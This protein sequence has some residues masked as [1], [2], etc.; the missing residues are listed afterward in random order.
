MSITD[1]EVR[2]TKAR[3]GK[4]TK[5]SVGHGLQLWAHPSGRRSWHLAYRAGGRQRMAALGTY[6]EVSLKAA[7]LRA[8]EVRL[9]LAKE[10]DPAEPP[11]AAPAPTFGAVKADWLDWIERGTAA[12]A[13][14]EKAVWLVSLTASIDARPIATLRASDILA[15]L[16]P[17]EAAGQLETAARLRS[18]ISRIFRYAAASD[19]VGADPTTLLRGAITAPKPVGRAAIVDRPGFT[20]LMRAIDGYRGRGAVV[21]AGLMLLAL[22][23]ARPGELRLA[24]W[25]EF[26]LDEAVWYV[27]EERMKM[28]LPHRAPLARQ[29]VEIL[30]S[31]KAEDGLARPPSPFV[32]PSPRPTRALSENS[33]N[34]ALRTMGFAKEEVCAHGFRSSFSTL[35]NKSKLWAY[36][37]IERALAHQDP[38]EVRRAY[39]RDDYFEE[40]RRLM[41]WWADEISAMIAGG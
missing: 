2:A 33:F 24:K 40:R 18:T 13:T 26:D 6:P 19:L 21:R 31:L 25:E 22:T 37:A 34:A 30:R 28:R 35:A 15:V 27:P 5:L 36:D 9:Q 17:L 7:R 41:Q 32:L 11:A 29:T 10:S 12:P 1:A 14:K 20:R 8:A 39:H 38:N 23:A 4:L 3:D 16:R